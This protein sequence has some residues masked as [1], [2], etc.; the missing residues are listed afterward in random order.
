MYIIVIGYAGDLALL[1][2]T[3]NK[4][5][6]SVQTLTEETNYLGLDSELTMEKW[7]FST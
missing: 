7:S 1:G 2:Q 6:R 4:M 3:K 5:E